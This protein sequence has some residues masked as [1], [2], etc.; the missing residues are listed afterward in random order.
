L[1]YCAEFIRILIKPC[2]APL[3]C[4]SHVPGI[5][6]AI[7]KELAAGAE[8]SPVPVMTNVGTDIFES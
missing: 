8:I 2:P 5:F 1:E 7:I 6:C 3:I 4:T